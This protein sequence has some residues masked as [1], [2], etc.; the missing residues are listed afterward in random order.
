MTPPS[1]LPLSLGPSSLGQREVSWGGQRAGEDAVRA[2][3]QDSSV[4]PP[5]SRAL[6]RSC[7]HSFYKHLLR[8][9]GPADTGQLRQDSALGWGVGGRCTVCARFGWGWG[10]MRCGEGRE[11]CNLL[12]VCFLRAFIVL[13]LPTNAQASCLRRTAHSLTPAESWGEPRF[14]Q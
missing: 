7:V 8:A 3:T 10:E 2:G 9:L 11:V 13:W 6:T 14:D 5:S 1:P 4:L 12:F